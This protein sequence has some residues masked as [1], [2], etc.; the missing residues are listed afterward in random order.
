MTVSEMTYTASFKDVF[1]IINNEGGIISEGIGSEHDD[2]NDMD[3]IDI[4]YSLRETE[5][6]GECRFS[7][8]RNGSKYDNGIYRDHYT[9]IAYCR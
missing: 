1:T 4:V 3:V 2:F 9:V 5:R 8:F 6:A 7:C